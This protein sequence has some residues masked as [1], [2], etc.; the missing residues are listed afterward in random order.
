MTD[1][2]IEFRNQA[3]WIAALGSGA[4]YSARWLAINVV[5]PLTTKHI[6]YLASTAKQFGQQTETLQAV[7]VCL[8]QLSDQHKE[9]VRCQQVHLDI[10]RERNP[11]CPLREL[12]LMQ[13]AKISQTEKKSHILEE[14]ANPNPKSTQRKKGSYG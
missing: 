12:D 5:K 6:E 1:W 3:P 11:T 4:V 14:E 2:L 9:L 10:C 8:H 13:L 7:Q